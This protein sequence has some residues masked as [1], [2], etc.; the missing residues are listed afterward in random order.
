MNYAF[1]QRRADV[2]SHTKHT[3][4]GIQRQPPLTLLDQPFVRH[5]DVLRVNDD[6]F[7]VARAHR[8]VIEADVQQV[9]RKLKV[10]VGELLGDVHQLTRQVYPLL[11]GR[12]V[13]APQL[14]AHVVD[15]YHA[16]TCSQILGKWPPFI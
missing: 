15:S 1:L 10:V 7:S 11:P 14:L 5:Q 9:E 8:E 16:P 6:D 12:V 3:S 2:T 4:A 13:V